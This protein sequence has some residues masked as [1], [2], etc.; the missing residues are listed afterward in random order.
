MV[1]TRRSMISQ[2]N[3][4]YTCYHSFFVPV[5]FSL[6]KKIPVL[7][8]PLI[9][10]VGTAGFVRLVVSFSCFIYILFMSN[11]FWIIDMYGFH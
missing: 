1:L 10:I 6:R 8:I 7:I 4:V 5:L 9:V 11:L 2:P 3:N